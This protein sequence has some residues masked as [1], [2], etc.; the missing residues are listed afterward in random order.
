M[1]GS[2][3][4]LHRSDKGEV[5]SAALFGAEHCVVCHIHQVSCSLTMFRVD[6][7]TDTGTEVMEYYGAQLKL[8][9]IL[10]QRLKTIFM[11]N[12]P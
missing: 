6:A 11:H 5:V 12:L 8:P 4:G 10:G 1:K 2:L 9:P 3:S 7:D